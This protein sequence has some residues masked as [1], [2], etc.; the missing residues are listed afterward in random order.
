MLSIDN[1]TYIKWQE[2]YASEELNIFK[3]HIN[4]PDV[5]PKK[6]GKIFLKKPLVK[7]K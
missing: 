2:K 1:F 6:I 7:K 5:N 3:L 4:S